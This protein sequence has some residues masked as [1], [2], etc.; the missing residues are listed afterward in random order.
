[1]K[2]FLKTVIDVKKEDISRAKSKLPLTALR[3]DAEHTPAPVSFA[4]AMAASTREAVGII[5]EVK[6]ASPSKGDIRID[7]DVAAYAKAYTK[8]GARAISVLTES[9]YFKGTLSDLEL[10]CKNTDIPVLRKDFIF[11]E[12]QIYETKKAG[13]SA[14]L[15]ITTLLDP[16]QQAELTLLTRELGMEPLVEINSEFE[17]EQA[18]KAQARVV[19]I[20]NRNLTTLEVDTSVARRVAKIFPGEII[21]VEAS[22]ISGRSG[23]E[24]GMENR[25]FNF[26]VGESIV[27]SKE[28]A[29]FIKTLLGIKAEGE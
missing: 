20:N 12:Y 5:A 14:V 17:F 25:I 28:P 1:M 8:G 3:H 7:L 18:Y 22:G 19:G 23:I 10:V 9:K 6:K 26:L 13:A 4:E 29:K 27:R 16:A 11:S 24:A 15:L 21:P 2:G